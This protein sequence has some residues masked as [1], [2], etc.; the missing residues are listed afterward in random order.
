M[1]IAAYA[2]VACSALS[3]LVMAASGQE[4]RMQSKDIPRDLTSSV[5]R[6]LDD[7]FQ[8]NCAGTTDA[9][10]HHIYDPDSVLHRR[11]S[12]YQL[13]DFGWYVS[14]KE[15]TTAEKRNGLEFRGTLVVTASAYRTY[16]SDSWTRWF[17]ESEHFKFNIKRDKGGSWVLEPFPQNTLFIKLTC[18][19]VGKLL[20]RPIKNSGL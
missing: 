6:V 18:D 17:D 2:L 20:T 12:T 4:V 16:D 8:R 13:A 1:R 19:E 11:E 14:R 7:A 9:F 3:S 5:E 15:L 10:D